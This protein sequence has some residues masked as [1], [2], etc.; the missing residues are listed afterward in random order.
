MGI[1]ANTQSLALDPKKMGMGGAFKRAGG[2]M[3]G[4]LRADIQ[5]RPFLGVN[6]KKVEYGPGTIYA[7]CPSSLGFG[8][9]RTVIFQLVGFYCARLLPRN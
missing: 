8:G 6:S 4:R 2:L 3:E 1:L 9:W 5:M 7:G